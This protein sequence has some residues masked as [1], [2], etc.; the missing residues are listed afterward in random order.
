MPSFKVVAN[1]KK[2]TRKEVL[3]NDFGAVTA[4][5]PYVI[6]PTVVGL[7]GWGAFALAVGGTWLLGAIFDIPQWR[8]G[9]AAIGS[10][11]L[12]YTV[13]AGAIEKVMPH[14]LWRL[15][16]GLNGLWGLS[17][18][19]PSMPLQAGSTVTTTPDGY[20]VQSYKQLTEATTIPDNGM[21]DYYQGNQSAAPVARA[22]YEDRM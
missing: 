3:M 20:Q 4:A 1:F 14:P 15:E 21:A 22:S 5:V 19:T 11:H 9:A 16:G 8:Q 10:A 13:F 18:N 12:C 7:N 6:L 2:N 17:D